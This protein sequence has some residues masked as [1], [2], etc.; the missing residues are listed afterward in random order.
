MSVVAVGTLQ[1]LFSILFPFHFLGCLEAL[2]RAGVVGS[3][4]RGKSVQVQVKC[5]PNSASVM[6]CPGPA[7][8]V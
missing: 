1:V 3:P 5:S 2:K 7:D 6:R 4:Q 8:W